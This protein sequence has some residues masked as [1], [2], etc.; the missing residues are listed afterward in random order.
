MRTFI[1]DEKHVCL[2]ILR[3]HYAHLAVVMILA[4]IHFSIEEPSDSA[5]KAGEMRPAKF[6]TA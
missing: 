2:T 6:V 5:E 1:I 4:L 3:H